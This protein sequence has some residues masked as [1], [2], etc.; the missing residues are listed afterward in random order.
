MVQIHTHEGF[1][2]DRV[3]WDF[4]EEEKNR[5]KEIM[6]ELRII[7]Q[8]ESVGMTM[9]PMALTQNLDYTIAIKIYGSPPRCVFENKW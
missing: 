4:S 2:D 8:A 9:P 7:F 5:I 3:A 6:E 1:Y